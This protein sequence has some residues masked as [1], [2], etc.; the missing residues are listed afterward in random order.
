V[1]L[2]PKDVQEILRIFVE[3]ELEELRLDLGDTRLHVSKGGA[4]LPEAPLPPVAP[5]RTAPPSGDPSPPSTPPP[6]P[7]PGDDSASNA[8]PTVAAA[9]V[10]GLVDLRSPLLGVFYRRPSP[11]EAPFV[12]VGSEVG[13]DDPVCVIDVMKMFTRVPAGTAGRIAEICVEDGQLVEHGQ[14]L[15][16][17]AP[18]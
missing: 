7:P 14:V 6:G 4:S 3:S 11:E 13:P 8:G 18:L 2:K 10:E 9:S 17:I 16:R 5:Q 12:E 15:V 1:E